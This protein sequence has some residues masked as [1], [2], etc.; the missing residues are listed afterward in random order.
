M[1]SS[2][3]R[4]APGALKKVAGQDRFFATAL[5]PTAS[6]KPAWSGAPVAGTRVAGFIQ[7]KANLAAYQDLCGFDRSEYVPATWLHVQTFALQTEIMSSRDWPFPVLGTVHVANQMRQFRPVH[8]DEELNI[9][10][11]V[12]QLYP[13]A[14]GTITT[15]SCSVETGRELVWAGSQRL[16]H[17]PLRHPRPACAIPARKRTPCPAERPPRGSRGFGQAVRQGHR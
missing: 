16:P 1:F 17:P 11:Q 7:D 13:H 10:V 14:K 15:M 12:G 9:G 3:S 5:R 4:S 8:I 2:T 6:R